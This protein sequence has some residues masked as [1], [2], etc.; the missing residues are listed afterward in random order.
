[1][2][3]DD[4]G[5]KTGTLISRSTRW[6]SCPCFSFVMEGYAGILEKTEVCVVAH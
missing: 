2:G 5:F 1:M 4:M 6:Y 3:G